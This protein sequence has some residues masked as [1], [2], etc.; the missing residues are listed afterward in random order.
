LID[1]TTVGSPI[2]EPNPSE[3]SSA[4]PAVKHRTQEPSHPLAEPHGSAEP[5]EVPGTSEEIDELVALDPDGDL[6]QTGSVIS[7]EEDKA[8]ALQRVLQLCGRSQI[9]WKHGDLEKAIETLDEAYA[10]LLEVD[11]EDHPGFLQEKEDLRITISRRMLEIYSSR[12][13]AVSRNGRNEIPVHINRHVQ[14]EIDAFTT[15]GEKDFFLAAY[16]RSGRYRAQIEAALETAGL[17]AEL[18]WLPL[19]ESGFKVTALSSKRALGLWQ[20]I[21]TTGYRYHLHRD[22]YID[23]R[24]DVGKSTRG[25]I[26]YLKELHEMFGDWTTVL[27]AYNCGENRVLRMIQSQH[28]NYLDNFW[29][30]YARLPRETAR[31]VPRFLA[32]LH[33]VQNLD[34]YGLSDV[35]PDPPLQSE[36]VAVPRQTTLSHIARA[37][38][39][40][41]DL[42]KELNAELRRGILPADGYELRVP[43]GTGILVARHADNFPIYAMK[44]QHLP[45]THQVRR[46]ETLSSIS[47]RYH[48]PVKALI[49]AN[50]IR[51]A[52]TI[53]AGTVLRIPGRHPAGRNAF[54]SSRPS[55]TSRT[56]T[57]VVRPGDSI[58]KIAKRFATTMDRIQRLNRLTTTHL[59]VGQILQIRTV[60]GLGGEA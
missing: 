24:L 42:L 33:I 19:V 25:A 49:S 51:S 31:Y 52:K 20:F 22:A 14:A 2:R 9:E 54:A 56:I 11:P 60:G 57:Y 27:A 53:R 48:V 47:R 39:I 30:L 23:E 40:E 13:V 37:T 46:G 59:Y 6:S 45:Q 36:I 5:A 4:L 21:P 3:R 10:L 29:D 58:V 35:A 16:R 44:P 41:G 28:I 32:T 1:T 17:P 43:P 26:E 18:A 50:G 8:I 55:P 38:G 34:T 7:T 12:L 15:G